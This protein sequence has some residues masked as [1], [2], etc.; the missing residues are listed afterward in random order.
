M[1]GASVN[2]PVVRLGAHGHDCKLESRLGSAISPVAG[3]LPVTDDQDSRAPLFLFNRRSR[4]R[5]T[6]RATTSLSVSTCRHRPCRDHDCVAE[7]GCYSLHGESGESVGLTGPA[8]RKLD[9]ANLRAGFN[10]PCNGRAEPRQKSQEPVQVPLTGFEHDH[11]L[12]KL[13]IVE[14][15]MRLA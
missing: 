6:G 1:L 4:R 14:C 10:S 11:G 13:Y 8:K 15:D 5:A 7:L 12:N 2:H 9:S 3:A